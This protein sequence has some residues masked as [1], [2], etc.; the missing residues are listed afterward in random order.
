MEL[1]GCSPPRIMILDPRSIRKT[2]SNEGESLDRRP[3]VSSPGPPRIAED[4]RSRWVARVTAPLALG[5]CMLSVGHVPVV[6][7]ATF[8]TLERRVAASADDAEEFIP[9]GTTRLA[10]DDLELIHDSYDQVVG[11]RWTALTIPPGS[12]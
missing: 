12:T 8:L 11:I 10:S 3:A 7:A 2:M 4:Q 1:H 6:K 9:R 5:L